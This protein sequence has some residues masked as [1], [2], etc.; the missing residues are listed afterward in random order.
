MSQLT[1]RVLVRGKFDRP[2]D[3]K[4]LAR[5]KALDSLNARFGRGTVTFASMG[6]K[7]GWKLRSE[8][9][10]PRYTT[11]WNDLLKV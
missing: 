4:A 7:P 10:S 3:A 8:F 9:K 5:M 11:A 1:Y 2:D 6:H